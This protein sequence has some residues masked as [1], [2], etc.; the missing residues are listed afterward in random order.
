MPPH[1]AE[2]PPG[3]G[4]DGVGVAPAID[5][6]GQGDGEGRPAPKRPR[7][8]AQRRPHRA[9]RLRRLTRGPDRVAHLDPTVA[10]IRWDLVQRAAKRGKGVFAVKRGGNQAVV[11]G[12]AVA[13]RPV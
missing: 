7:R 9:V 13:S 5:H 4:G 11:D 1:G 6:R 8:G 12:A 3:H 10:A 2:Q